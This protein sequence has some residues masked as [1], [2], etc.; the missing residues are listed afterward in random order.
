MLVSAIII[1]DE[2]QRIDG[3]PNEILINLKK[4]S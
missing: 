2:L 3:I 4:M 1:T